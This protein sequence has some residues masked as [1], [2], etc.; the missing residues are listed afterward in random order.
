MD[1]IMFPLL[2]APFASDDDERDEAGVREEGGSDRTVA[3][4]P[5][6]PSAPDALTGAEFVQIDSVVKEPAAD[7]PPLR[8]G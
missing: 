3:G 8:E 5:L 1:V 6:L 7:D 4:E 2:P